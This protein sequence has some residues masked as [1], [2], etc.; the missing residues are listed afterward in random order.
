MLQ[1]AK[2]LSLNFLLW[3]EQFD[4]RLKQLKEAEVIL[5]LTAGKEMT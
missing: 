3:A 1:K 5:K 2:C 4:E